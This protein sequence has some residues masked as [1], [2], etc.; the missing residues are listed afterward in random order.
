MGGH[1][2]LQGILLTQGLSLHL[3]NWQ[4]DSLPW[5][6]SRAGTDTGKNESSPYTVHGKMAMIIFL[7]V[8]SFIY[9]AVPG[10]SCGLQDL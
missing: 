4:A 8:S 3:L 1:F 6:P 10:S 2:L 9:S 7:N 5:K